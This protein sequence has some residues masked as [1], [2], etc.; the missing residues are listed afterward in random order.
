[1]LEACLQVPSPSLW[2]YNIVPMET[3][4]LTNRM[5]TEPIVRQTDHFHWH[6]DK[7]EC[8]GDGDGTCKQALAHTSLYTHTHGR[9]GGNFAYIC[10]TLKHL[11]LHTHNDVAR[12]NSTLNLAC[13][14]ND[15]AR[16]PFI[17]LTVVASTRRQVWSNCRCFRKTPVWKKTSP[18]N[19]KSRNDEHQSPLIQVPWAVAVFSV[20]LFCGK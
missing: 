11:T 10:C 18:N 20:D 14:L 3:V 16:W 19:S 8:H 15:V 9:Q 17:N 13:T 7:L 5:G 1:M 4:C 2:K 6:N 12:W